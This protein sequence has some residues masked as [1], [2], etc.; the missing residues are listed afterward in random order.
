MSKLQRH[1]LFVYYTKTIKI[2]SY[3]C[4]KNKPMQKHSLLRYLFI[5]SLTGIILL[6][7]SYGWNIIKDQKKEL[8]EQAEKLRELKPALADKLEEMAYEYETNKFYQLMPYINLLF[9]LLSLVGV[10]L[11]WQLNWKGWYIYLFAEFAPYILTL[12][13]WKEYSHYSDLMGMSSASS[14]VITL[15]YVGFDILFAGLYYYALKESFKLTDAT[16]SQEQTST[17]E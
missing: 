8:L 15:I 5:L 14:I 3:L 17:N 10:I 7:L 1:N 9:L 16:P 4:F 2:I 11:M 12:V 6:F 13:L